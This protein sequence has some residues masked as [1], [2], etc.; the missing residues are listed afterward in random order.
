MTEISFTSKLVP[1]KQSDF[2]NIT[3]AFSRDCF[4][5]YPWT[6]SSSK[7]G[8]DVFTHRI[9]DCSAFLIT[10][11]QKAI[12]KHLCP[13][14]ESNHHFTN[15]LD[16]LRNNI[17]LKDVNLQAVLVG[18]KNTKPSQD[19]WNKFI[20]LLDYLKIPATILKDGK[21]PTHLAYRT[22]RDEVLISNEHIEK[23]LKQG[24]N[25]RDA[26]FNGFHEVKISPFDEF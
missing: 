2:H 19:I 1:L 12:L 15:V 21:S 13:S 20:D 23:L 24:V 26:I 8:K 4:V 14:N 7:I 17:D 6:I 3:S 18:S 16:F 5:D 22:C 11:G 9:C 10:D 25:N